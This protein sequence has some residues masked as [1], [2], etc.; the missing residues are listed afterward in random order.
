METVKII[1]NGGSQA[2]RLPMRYRLKGTEAF[3]KKI[4]GGVMLLEKNDV[5]ETFE[6]SLNEFPKDFLKKRKT[7][8]KQSKRSF[9]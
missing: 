6:K 7:S 2:V 1:K 3:V 4:N 9:E 5:W 8:R